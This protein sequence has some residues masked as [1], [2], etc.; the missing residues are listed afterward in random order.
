MNKAIV[1]LY[2]YILLHAVFM[3]LKFVLVNLTAADDFLK[4]WNTEFRDKFNCLTM[5]L[6]FIFIYTI[7][8][9]IYIIIYRHIR[10]VHERATETTC[11]IC[12][13][14]L[15]DIDSCKRHMINVHK[16]GT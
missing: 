10:T 3:N 7:N 16:V 14:K 4:S 9:P 13:R 12:G 5:A 11:E 1:K 2:I 6:L 15:S 8:L